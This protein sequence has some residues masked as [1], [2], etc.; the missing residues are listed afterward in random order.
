MSDGG[1]SATVEELRLRVRTAALLSRTLGELANLIEHAGRLGASG[2]PH[3]AAVLRD[4]DAAMFLT[5]PPAEVQEFLQELCAGAAA[6]GAAL[7]ASARQSE[8]G[9]VCEGS[10]TIRKAT[11]E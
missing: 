3:L 1:M 10:P 5:R 6:L 8:E 7:H 4:L 9:R 2:T 11:R